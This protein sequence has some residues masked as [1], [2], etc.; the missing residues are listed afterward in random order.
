M[1]IQVESL[2]TN[3]GE[4]SYTPA[5]SGD[6]IQHMAI[7]N[8]YFD[9]EVTP[10]ESKKLAAIYQFAMDKAQS[11]NPADVIWEVI[12]LEGVLGA[13]RMGESRFERL[14]RYVQL[15]KEESMIQEELRNVTASGRL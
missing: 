14:Y 15:R 13:P 12:N 8:R 1:E 10:A 4:P 2:P 3:P 7:A 9:G 5:P 11:I 6:S